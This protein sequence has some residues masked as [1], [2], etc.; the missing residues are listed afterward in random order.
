MELWL[1]IIVACVPSLAPIFKTYVKPAVA[2]IGTR[3]GTGS[4]HTESRSQYR[5]RDVR[6]SAFCSGGSERDTKPYRQLSDDSS[7]GSE[8]V[9]ER[10]GP[11]TSGVGVRTECSFDPRAQAGR[12]AAGEPTVP[13]RTL[14]VDVVTNR[15]SE[16]FPDEDDGRGAQASWV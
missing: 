7:L 11:D 2:R 15:R 5:L 16:V 9:E 8:A 4:A 12:E 10:K 1:G 14:T 6:G 13:R 3:S